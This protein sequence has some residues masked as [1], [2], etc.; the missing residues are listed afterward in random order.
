MKEHTKH[1]ENLLKK[2]E[3][4]DLKIKAVNSQLKETER[5]EDTRLKVLL[6]AAVL[7]DV[8]HHPETRAGIASAVNRAITAEKDREF[9]KS[10]GWL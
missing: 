9:L 2:R 4:F 1:L 6:G 7:T 10:K 8:A 5:R 3:A